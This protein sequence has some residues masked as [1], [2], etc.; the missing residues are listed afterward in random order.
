MWKLISK[1][2]RQA[3]VVLVLLASCLGFYGSGQAASALSRDYLDAYF[4]SLTAAACLGEYTADESM[5]FNYLRIM[6]WD[7][8]PVVSRQGKLE[9]HFSVAKRHF[10]DIGKDVYLVCFR[11]STTK[12]DWKINFKTKKVNYGGT[13]LQAMQELAAKPLVKDGPAVHGGFNEYADIVLK[14]SV[15]NPENGR[16]TGIFAEVKDKQDTLLLLT[17]HSMGG[18]VATLV[19]TRLADLGIPRDRMGVITFGA[20][21]IGTTEYN[22]KYANKLEILRIIN[23]YDPIPGSLQTFFSGYVQCGRKQEHRLTN[24]I[25]NVQHDMAMYFDS[26]IIELYKTKDKEIAAGRLEPLAKKRVIPGKPLVA[27]WAENSQGLQK[28][29][30][31]PD[32]RRM[33]FDQY[34]KFI[35]SYVI[36]E[37]KLRTGNG[38]QD[39]DLLAASRKAGADYLIVCSIDSLRHKERD[40]AWYIIQEQSLLRKDGALLSM[41]N[42]AKK[43]T[44]SRGNVQTAGENC[45]VAFAELQKH[46][47]FIGELVED[48]IQ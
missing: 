30:L 44:P 13:T 2:F 16:L 41:T 43:V 3:L 20:P 45:L 24:R 22:E 38:L 17:G 14:E 6:G 27:L 47:P 9:T 7:I 15:L 31:M 23:T 25:G 26:S 37:D 48:T 46:L 4:T 42:F 32:L 33:L 1:S 18:A 39:Q 21:A 35:P 8:V 28:M 10:K 5:E 12:G 40:D 36:L 29:P 11:G 34:A 19:A